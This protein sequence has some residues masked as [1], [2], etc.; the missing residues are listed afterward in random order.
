MYS[1]S[2]KL[3]AC[4]PS[5]SGVSFAECSTM[6]LSTGLSLFLFLNACIVLVEFQQWISVIQVCSSH[7]LAIVFLSKWVCLTSQIPNEAYLY[8]RVLLIK[9]KLGMCKVQLKIYELQTTVI[10]TKQIRVTHGCTPDL[11]RQY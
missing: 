7:A 4:N 6:Y 11:Q 1:E 8:S 5:C 9:K 10:R 2:D 3:T